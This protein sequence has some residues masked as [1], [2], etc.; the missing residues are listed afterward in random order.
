[1]VGFQVSSLNFDKECSNRIEQIQK[2][3][4]NPK[5]KIDNNQKNRLEKQID[6]LEGWSKGQNLEELYPA[7]IFIKCAQDIEGE[8]EDKIEKLHD[9]NLDFN[10]SNKFKSNFRE[11]KDGDINN[12]EFD[13]N[14]IKISISG[15]NFNYKF[16]FDSI[17]N[18]HTGDAYDLAISSKISRKN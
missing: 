14:N 8:S 7:T 6:K 15:S 9:K 13:N 1:M 12:V 2:V 5:Y 11:L 10:F 3:L 16:L 17:I 18:E 4:N